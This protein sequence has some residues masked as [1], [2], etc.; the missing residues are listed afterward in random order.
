MKFQISRYKG[1]KVGIF[2]ISS[3]RSVNK[4]ADQLCGYRTADFQLS[5]RIYAKTGFS[6]DMTIGTVCVCV[7]QFRL[8]CLKT[9]SLG[10]N[11]LGTT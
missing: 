7:V 3:M 4:G 5:Y 11:T 1:F 2:S 9:R 10:L 6:H 8:C